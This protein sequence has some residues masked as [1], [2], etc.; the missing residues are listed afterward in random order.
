MFAALA[1]KEKNSIIGILK[2]FVK[3][4]SAKLFPARQFLLTVMLQVP[5]YPT[6]NQFV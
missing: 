6:P 4:L 2:K 5:C 3:F 1:R